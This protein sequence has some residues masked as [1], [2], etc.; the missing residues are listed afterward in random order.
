MGW[1]PLAPRQQLP[2]RLTRGDRSRRPHSRA[3]GFGSCLRLDCGEEPATCR[4]TMT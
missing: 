4:L 2:Q 1:R 3:S